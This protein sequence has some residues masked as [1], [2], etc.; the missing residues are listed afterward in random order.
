MSSHPYFVSFR[1]YLVG[2]VACV[3]FYGALALV[4]ASSAVGEFILARGPLQPVACFLFLSGLALLGERHVAQRTEA[5]WRW[6]SLPPGALPRSRAAAV[7]DTLDGPGAS[8]LNRRLLRDL[9]RGFA[10][11][12]DLSLLLRDL[13]RRADDELAAKY[14]AVATLRTLLP[15]V[16]L[17]GTV[18]G[19]SRGMLHF[20]HSSRAA[21]LD[22]LRA[23]LQAFA[24][25]ASTA[26]DTTLLGLGCMLVLGLGCVALQRE[27]RR[28]VARWSELLHENSRRLC[29]E[30]TSPAKQELQLDLLVER[31]EQRF[32][33]FSDR[34]LATFASRLHETLGNAGRGAV[35]EF[36]R[37]L[38]GATQEA[39]R[40]MGDHV[41]KLV[42]SALR[43]HMAVIE[44]EI[45]RVG[46]RLDQPIPLKIR[47]VGDSVNGAVQHDA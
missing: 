47:L 35:E 10:R 18:F 14:S 29:V 39:L 6:P 43:G 4:A 19:L 38:E 23:T 15:V 22:S 44:A 21:D 9:L 27:D 25:S 40:P 32:A 12:D 28:M 36:Q 24:A 20:A 42:A 16:G 5:G 34:L 45:A 13:E 30:T 3:L 41:G 2:A 37:S 46:R 17:L 31:F 1:P 26:F 33:L 7:A 8:D 11:G